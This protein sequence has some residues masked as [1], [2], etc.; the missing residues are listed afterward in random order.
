[1][2]SQLRILAACILSLAVVSQAGATSYT[3][4]GVADLSVY[5][6]VV[7]GD[8]DALD[9]EPFGPV[10]FSAAGFS[11]SVHSWVL[12]DGGG[13]YTFVYHV[14]LDASSTTDLDTFRLMNPAEPYLNVADGVILGAGYNSTLA[15]LHPDGTPAMARSYPDDLV[16]VFEFNWTALIGA[17]PDWDIIGLQ[18]GSAAEMFIRTTSNVVI[19]NV[20]GMVIDGSSAAFETWGPGDPTVPEPM[21]L[22]LVA[23]ALAGIGVRAARHRRARRA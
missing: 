15:G 7:Y 21:T 3:P 6:T 8:P 18:P 22:L 5:G 9:G 2:A 10:S 17:P 20:A 11:G 23:S 16:P 19:Q 1:M 4:V 12:Q 14:E 13:N